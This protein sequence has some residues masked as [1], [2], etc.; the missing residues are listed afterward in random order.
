MERF[1]RG[2]DNHKR[3]SQIGRLAG[4]GNSQRQL[5]ENNLPEPN[6]TEINLIVFVFSFCMGRI[7]QVSSPR[8]ARKLNL[9]GRFL[10]F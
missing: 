5:Q 8:C 9:R 6:A 2:G 3:Q 7:R 10:V 4:T 1:A